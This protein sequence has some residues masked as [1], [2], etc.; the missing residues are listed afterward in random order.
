MMVRCAIFFGV[1]LRIDRDG[2]VGM[3]LHEVPVVSLEWTKY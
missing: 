3:S 1:I 2:K